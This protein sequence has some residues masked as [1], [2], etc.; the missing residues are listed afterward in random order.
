MHPAVGEVITQPVGNDAPLAEIAVELERAEL[1]LAEPG[2]ELDLF[3]GRDQRRAVHE[4]SRQCDFGLEQAQLN[5]FHH[6]NF[7]ASSAATS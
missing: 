3:V 2:G 5:G 6:V 1:E 4:A 7:V